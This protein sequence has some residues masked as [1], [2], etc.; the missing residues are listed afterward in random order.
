M[1]YLPLTIKATSPPP[2]AATAANPIVGRIAETVK[3]KTFLGEAIAVEMLRSKND[4]KM[5]PKIAT[6]KAASKGI[7]IFFIIKFS[8]INYL[9]NAFN[10]SLL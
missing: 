2:I 4:P 6:A 9:I 3:P 5:I 7:R 10:S 8:F 1:W